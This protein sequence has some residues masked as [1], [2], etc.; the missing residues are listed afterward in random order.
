MANSYKKRGITDIIERSPNINS[1][2]I[3][4]DIYGYMN[5]TQQSTKNSNFGESKDRRRDLIERGV[6][7]HKA[8]GKVTNFGLPKSVC[9]VPAP[10][11]SEYLQNIADYINQSSIFMMYKSE[12]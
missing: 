11:V 4:S 7:L 2:E 3:I 9:C 12:Q 5:H 6:R 8:S 1:Q 10:T